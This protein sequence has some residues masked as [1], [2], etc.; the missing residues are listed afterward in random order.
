MGLSSI[1]GCPFASKVVAACR[2]PSRA[3]RAACRRG[4]FPIFVALRF[5]PGARA[6]SVRP[7]S[8]TEPQ[9]AAPK[10]D[11]RHHTMIDAMPHAIRLPQPGCDHRER[12]STGRD[13]LDALDAWLA[14]DSHS[15]D[16]VHV[17][18]WAERDH[19]SADRCA[20]HVRDIQ[21]NESIVP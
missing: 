3:P 9:G 4:P 20:P 2:P 13:L 5:Q 18:S 19:D 1:S 6:V 12:T 21:F 8:A 16:Y 10:T 15:A 17:H 11:E 14:D 7:C